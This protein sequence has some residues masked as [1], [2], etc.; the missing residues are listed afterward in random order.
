MQLRMNFLAFMMALLVFLNSCKKESESEESDSYTVSTFAGRKSG[1]FSEVDGPRSSA[2]V[3]SP[4]GLAVDQEGNVFVSGLYGSIRKITPSGGVST[5]ARDLGINEFLSID[6]QGNLYASSYAGSQS[7]YKITPSGIVTTI[8]RVNEN[9]PGYQDGPIST[10]KFGTIAGTAVDAQGNIF[11]ADQRNHRIRKIT[12]GGMVST[13]AGTGIP[14][15]VGGMDTKDGPGNVAEFYDPTSLAF[16]R[17][18]N[19]YVTELRRRDDLGIRKITPD[20]V[21]STLVYSIPDEY[22]TDPYGIVIDREG[23]IFLTE[24]ETGGRMTRVFKISRSGRVSVIAGTKAFGYVDGDGPT[25]LFT[26]LGG[27]TIDGQGNLYVADQG[28]H[29][30]RKISKK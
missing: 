7:L 17:E 25:A 8:V 23:N 12:P 9:T 10:A 3:P 19:L 2:T 5:L 22:K 14:N 4:K 1:G 27:I 13:F 30:V 26:S 18:G 15:F 29:A 21:V 28:N 20:G 11:V 24:R 16:D 6:A